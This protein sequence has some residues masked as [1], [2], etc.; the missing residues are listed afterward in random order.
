MSD[1]LPQK[2]DTT[3][4]QFA[5][6]KREGRQTV[7]SLARLLLI[8]TRVLVSGIFF[9]GFIEAY[10]WI[11]GITILPAVKW[12]MSIGGSLIVLY[13]N[14][15]GYISDAIDMTPEWLKNLFVKK[16]RSDL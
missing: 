2:S 6:L 12:T 4:E 8:L 1:N 13:I 16:N 5:D 11:N 10:Q 3:D 7:I 9:M 14:I 15:A